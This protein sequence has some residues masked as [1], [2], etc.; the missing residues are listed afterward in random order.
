MKTKMEGIFRMLREFE[1]TANEG[2]FK[3]IFGDYIYKHLWNK[4]TIIHNFN[5]I[6]FTRT[7]DRENHELLMNY[8]EEPI[9]RQAKTLEF[10]EN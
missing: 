6:S 2:T 1:C 3:K 9:Q 8:F 5:L 10:Q 4:F 7:L